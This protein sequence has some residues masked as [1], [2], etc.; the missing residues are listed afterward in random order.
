MFGIALFV[1]KTSRKS[2]SNQVLCRSQ[3]THVWTRFYLTTNNRIPTPK[4]YE[5]DL[6]IHATLTSHTNETP[7]NLLC[8]TNRCKTCPVLKTTNECIRKTTGKQFTIKI[9]ISCKPSN[10]VYLIKCRRCGLQYVS[11]SGQPLHERMNGHWFDITHG[12]IEVSPLAAHLIVLV[13]LRP[14]SQYVW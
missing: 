10:I 11:E 13:T 9:H 3:F 5:R 8:S 14:T 4:K 12:R 7:G 6:L 1:S 2:I